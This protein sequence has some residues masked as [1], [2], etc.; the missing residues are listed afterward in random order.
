MQ[1]VFLKIIES[2]YSRLPYLPL[3]DCAPL[4]KMHEILGGKHTFYVYC[5]L[6]EQLEYNRRLLLFLLVCCT[7]PSSHALLPI[8]LVAAQFSSRCIEN[9][10]KT[11]VFVFENR[12]PNSVYYTEQWYYVLLLS[13]VPDSVECTVV[14]LCY[15]NY[16]TMLVVILHRRLSLES[17]QLLPVQAFAELLLPSTLYLFS[18]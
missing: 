10:H 13:L 2:S 3:S 5:F 8:I 14:N 4:L 12:F 18:C 15:I 9:F 1:H 11:S 16:R 6:L 17:T 7:L